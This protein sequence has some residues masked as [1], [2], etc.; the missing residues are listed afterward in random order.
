MYWEYLKY[1]EIRN[2]ITIKTM[3]CAF[4]N[5]KITFLIKIT[6]LQ[7][8]FQYVNLTHCTVLSSK[9]WGTFTLITSIDVDT[10]SS[11]QTCIGIQALI[12][13]CK[14]YQKKLI[15]SIIIFFFSNS[16][17]VKKVCVWLCTFVTEGTLPLRG[18]DTLER[19]GGVNTPGSMLTGVRQ[20]LI[21]I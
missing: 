18:T 5:F 16:W 6:T 11:I 20:T 14:I 15:I 17:W 21:D 3:I 1:L 2:E 19:P 10:G 13:V 4:I 9:S 8:I 7:R 12:L